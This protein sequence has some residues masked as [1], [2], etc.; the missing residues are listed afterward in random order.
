[1]NDKDIYKDAQKVNLITL[2]RTF[3]KEGLENFIVIRRN[4]FENLLKENEK[5]E[6]VKKYILKKQSIQ[7]KYA[8]SKIECEELLKI[9]EGK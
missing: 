6:K 7:Y 2:L 9:L 3:K 1:M 5:N 8:L 4:K